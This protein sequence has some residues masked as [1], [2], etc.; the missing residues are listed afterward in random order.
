MIA[1]LEMIVDAFTH[2]IE[3]EDEVII[4]AVVNPDS[5]HKLNRP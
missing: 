1:F 4:L 5:Y 2:P 3:G